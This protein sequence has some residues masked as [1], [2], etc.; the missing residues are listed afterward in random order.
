MNCSWRSG[1]CLT[2]LGL[3]INLRT[4]VH[5][6]MLT[7]YRVRTPIDTRT[8]CPENDIL[9]SR[10]KKS[11]APPSNPLVFIAATLQ[12]VYDRRP[13]T[14]MGGSLNGQRANA[15]GGVSRSF[16]DL[17]EIDSRLVFDIFW[18][19]IISD[20][21]RPLEVCPWNQDR[22]SSSIVLAKVMR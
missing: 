5:A 15:K 17:R 21:F 2:G 22:T 14:A 11:S 6:V 7:A 20:C 3:G 10:Q 12:I 9:T 4:L 1:A 8:T 19:V 16:E 18:R 13:R